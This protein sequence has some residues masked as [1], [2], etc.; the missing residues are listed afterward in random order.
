MNFFVWRMVTLLICTLKSRWEGYNLLSAELSCVSLNRWQFTKWTVGTLQV[1]F[2]QL[3]RWIHALCSTLVEQIWSM[4]PSSSWRN[5]LWWTWRNRW[6]FMMLLLWLSASPSN[7][8]LL[9]SFAKYK[10][11]AFL[12]FRETW[13]YQ[14]IL[15]WWGK[16]HKVGEK[17]WEFVWSGIFDCDTFALCIV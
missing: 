9:I 3:I 13:K 16:R 8:R 6:R 12:E 7:C 15:Q 14:G 5:K 17:V 1:C 4:T 2:C 10:V 11:T